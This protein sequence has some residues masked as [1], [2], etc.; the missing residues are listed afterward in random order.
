MLLFIVAKFPQHTH[1]THTI[2]FV[3]E[4]TDLAQVF[5]VCLDTFNQPSDLVHNFKGWF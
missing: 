5:Q 4:R 2:I 1:S 3:V